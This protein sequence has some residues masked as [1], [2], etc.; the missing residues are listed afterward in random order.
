[1]NVK[2]LLAALLLAAPALAQP[3]GFA[4]LGSDAAGFALPDPGRTL[5]FPRDHGPHD[6]FRI[7]WWYLTATLKDAQGRRYGAQWTLFRSAL[8]PSGPTQG[9]A[10]PQL[11][12]AHAAVTTPDA[13]FSAE[14]LARGGVGQAGVVAQPFSAWIDEWAMTAQG[15]DLDRLSLTARGD[16]FSYRLDARAEGPLVAH[17]A[18][19]YS[20]KSAGGQASHYYSQPF[21]RVT[22]T[23]TLPSGPVEVSGEG[24]LD[25]EWSSQPLDRTQTG[26]DWIALHLDD[27]R[28]LMAARVRGAAPFLF[29][30]LIGKDGAARPLDAAALRLTPGAR[31]PPTTWR[32]ELP[33]AGLDLTL[34]AVN[35]AAWMATSLRYWEGPVTVAG[36][37]SG[38]GYLEMTGY[39]PPK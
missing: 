12:M 35:P 4:G 25:R 5:A 20:V 11:W 39:P 27:G 9:W 2:A 7:E 14:R 17:G 16:G 24:W 33:D 10:S 21:Y 3:A 19:G 34:K 32:V 31:T 28:K 13:H 26:W 37:A 23:L 38:S 15:D 1:M 8:A 22:G 6:A 36:S 30:T 29:G 18:A